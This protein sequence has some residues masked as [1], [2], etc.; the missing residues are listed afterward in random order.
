[1]GAS[2]ALEGNN[3]EQDRASASPV[4]PRE[5]TKIH[6]VIKMLSRD[7]GATIGALTAAMR[8][9]PHTTRA[10]RS[11]LRKR[12]YAIERSRSGDGGSSAYRLTRPNQPGA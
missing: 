11:G 12:G 8:W 6:D 4:V 2:E 3:S 5:G 7:G 9:L 10:A 1:M